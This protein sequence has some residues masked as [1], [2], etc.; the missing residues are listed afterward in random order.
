ME[1]TGV[2]IIIPV[3]NEEGA[4]GSTI[5]KVKEAF[6][7]AGADFEVIVVDDGSTDNSAAMAENAG[8]K[9]FRHPVNTGY[10]NAI[11]TGVAGAKYDIVAIVDADGTYPIEILPQMAADLYSN[12]FDM[13]V[14]ARKGKIYYGNFVIRFARTMFRWLCEFTTGTSIPDTNSGLRVMRKDLVTDF[15]NVLCGGFSFTTTLTL[16]ATL[17]G[18]F[19]SY[20]DIRYFAREG[21]SKIHF[22]RDM[23]RALQIIT[24]AILNYNPIKLFLIMVL[25]LS[26][27]GLVMVV[28]AALFPERTALISLVSA[29][30]MAVFV[31]TALGFL[32]EQRRMSFPDRRLGRGK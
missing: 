9:L 10:G 21:K 19:V 24:M 8:A 29:F 25:K 17:S 18:R 7:A 32:A 6:A 14:G 30:L 4:V 2:S 13:I 31:I 5:A 28:L 1:R 23:L 27:I 16:V 20:T 22:R 15:W 3:Y 26:F 11:K 12:G